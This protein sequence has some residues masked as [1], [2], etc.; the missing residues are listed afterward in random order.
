MTKIK[1]Y[2]MIT[3]TLA[4]FSF[5]ALLFSHL[6]LTDIYHGETNVNMEWTIL[7]VAAIVFL[8]FIVSTIFTLRQVLKI[9]S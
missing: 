4:C 7:R 2:A 9:R 5:I 3:V 8:A 6:A 1:K